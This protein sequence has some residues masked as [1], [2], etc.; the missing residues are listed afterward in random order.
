MQSDTPDEVAHIKMTT[1]PLRRPNAL[2]AMVRVMQ[3][4]MNVHEP[5]KVVCF[6][7]AHDT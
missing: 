3:N 7:E 5:E 1:M 6:T 2:T 4:A